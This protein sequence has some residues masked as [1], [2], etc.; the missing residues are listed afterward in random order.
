MQMRFRAAAFM[1]AGLLSGCGS[2]TTPGGV[3][4]AVIVGPHHGTTI[5]LPDD[6]GFIELTNEPEVRTRDSTEPTAIVAYF[7]KLDGTSSLEPAPSDVKIELNPVGR[8]PAETIPLAA[9]PKGDDP[10]AGSRFVS[11]SGPHHLAMLRGKLSAK[12]DGQ[13]LSFP[14]TGSR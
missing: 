12:I 9:E 10:T 5:R 13:E 4:P 14:I 11:K 8:K 3:N 2:S 6:K 1:M 7:L